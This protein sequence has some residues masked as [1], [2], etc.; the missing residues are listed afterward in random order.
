MQCRE[1]RNFIQLFIDSELDARTNLEVS[2]HLSIC[3]DCNNRFMQEQKIEKGLAS[4]F[5]GNRDHLKDKREI[6]RIWEKA[7]SV[8]NEQ[9]D[10]NFKIMLK[11]K[12]L[13]PVIPAF[14][15]IV[16]LLIFSFNNRSQ[17]IIAASECH[18][19][20]LEN[21]ISPT[22][23]TQ[24]NEEVVNYFSNKFDFA[25]NFPHENHGENKTKL[26]GAR[27]C[28][29]KKVPVAYV[30]YSCNNFPLSLFFINNESLINFPGAKRLLIKHG[31][32]EE[33]NVHGSNLIAIRT[34]DKI[35]CAVS[36][37]DL[38]SLRDIVN[39]YK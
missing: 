4:I 19:E 26:V 34:K 9:E 30:M 27:L 37:M 29:L 14:I 10:R 5:S 33:K 21:K 17:L 13:V 8:I 31:I 6:D 3:E 36:E 7:T 22:I 25:I 32:I 24:I 12:Y 23:E 2:E 28:Y 39:G 11:R 20:Y 38:Q 15:A 1:V 16:L 35:V 18:T